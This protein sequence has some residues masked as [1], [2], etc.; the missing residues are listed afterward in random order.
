VRVE[1]HD[2]NHAELRDQ[3]SGGDRRRAKAAI[4]I[5]VGGDE[6]RTFTGELED[7]INYAL[8]RGLI[9]SW[10]LPQTLPRNAA[11]T[12]IADQI[13]DDLNLED[14]EALCAAV[15]PHYDRVLN[16]PKATIISGNVL[17]TTTSD[18]QAPHS[19]SVTT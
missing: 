18:G 3:L 19:L 4:Q 17:S 8:L 7:K 16:G 14:I 11:S 9:V 6:S 13:L 5:T 2:G 12:E 15:R 1:L 10:T